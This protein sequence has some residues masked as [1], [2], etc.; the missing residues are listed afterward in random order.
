MP[1]FN[2][3]NIGSFRGLPALSSYDATYTLMIEGDNGEKYNIAWPALVG[4]IPGAAVNWEDIGGDIAG[5]AAL[6]GELNNRAPAAALTAHEGA[7]GAAHAAATAADNGFMPAAH[8]SM[9]SGATSAP[10]ANQLAIRDENGRMQAA[11]GVADDDVVTVSQLGAAGSSAEALKRPAIFT[12][13][14]DQTVTAGSGAT[15][16]TFAETEDA[17]NEYSVTGGVITLPN[18]AGKYVVAVELEIN[19]PVSTTKLLGDV[20]LKHHD[21]TS[22]NT[23]L[24]RTVGGNATSASTAFQT[25]PLMFTARIDAADDGE[26]LQIDVDPLT[27]WADFKLLG[28]RCKV[29]I[30][31]IVT[32]GGGSGSASATVALYANGELVHAGVTAIDFLIA[33]QTV[34][35]DSGIGSISVPAPTAAAAGANGNVN[36]AYAGAF[37]A[38]S[39]MIYS[40]FNT[41]G[42]SNHVLKADQWRGRLYE[43]AVAAGG[44]FWPD[45]NFQTYYEITANGN[46]TI[47]ANNVETKGPVS[48]Q[49]GPN[50][51]VACAILE[52]TNNIASAI[53]VGLGSTGTN[54]FDKRIGTSENSISIPAGSTS[55]VTCWA[56]RRAN[57]AAVRL[58]QV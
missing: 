35:V 6:Q 33:G 41:L 13:G 4:L 29:S 56:K 11:A 5:N 57:G 44:R 24:T 53:T 52:I 12:L 58:I 17:D 42:A 43:V 47:E 50:S 15:T 46:F 2:P 25:M 23:I 26:T 18:G 16:V 10:T 8:F 36:F 30:F 9:L 27:S 37:F 39:I 32:V 21:G 22:L 1:D 45:V 28:G 7:G 38:S 34:G 54:A 31:K 14:S 40:P 49:A 20:I 3:K 55:I 19:A 51:E 48:G